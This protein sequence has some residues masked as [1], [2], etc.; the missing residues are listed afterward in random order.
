M[1]FGFLTVLRDAQ[2]EQTP[3]SADGFR[4][5]PGWYWA[6]GGGGGEELGGGARTRRERPRSPQPVNTNGARARLMPTP[7]SHPPVTRLPRGGASAAQAR[8]PPRLPPARGAHSP[9]PT[10]S[11]RARGLPQSCWGGRRAAGSPGGPEPPARL[12]YLP[13]GRGPSS[14]SLSSFPSRPLSPR[15]TLCSA[16]SGRGR[17][18]G[19]ARTLRVA[20][21]I[22]GPL[23][24]AGHAAGLRPPP[25]APRD[26]A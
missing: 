21:E 5:R 6:G 11:R 15:R 13:L 12:W 17:G 2:N 20:P 25:R 4:R 24:R 22:A 14:R 18:G 26:R 19:G 23:A 7:P 8:P 10:P 1:E 16:H 3:S 9:L